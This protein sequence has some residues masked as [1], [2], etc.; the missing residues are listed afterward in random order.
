MDVRQHLFKARIPLYN[1]ALDAY[2]LRQKTIAKNIANATTPDYRPEAVRFEEELQK[3]LISA[4]GARTNSG[5]ISMGDKS[6]GEVK[7]EAHLAQM[8]RAEIYHSGESHVNIDKEMAE[9]AQNQIRF[10]FASR[11]MARYFQG[12]Q[13]AAR[14]V[15][16]Q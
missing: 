7:G 11:T 10:R 13:G 3:T 1:K 4:P 2:A 15:S 14:G 9:L 5:H 16:P 8:P 6:L 12:L